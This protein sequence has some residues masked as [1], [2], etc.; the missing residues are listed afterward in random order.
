MES[1]GFE[2]LKRRFAASD[3]N[4]K[5]SMYIEAEDLDQSQYKELLHLFPLNELTLLEAALA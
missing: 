3:T 5:I 4:A 1:K 2:D